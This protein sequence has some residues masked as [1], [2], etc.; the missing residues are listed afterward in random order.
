MPGFIKT[1]LEPVEMTSDNRWFCPSCNYL[2]SSTKKIECKK[3]RTIVIFQLQCYTMFRSNPIKDNRKVKCSSDPLKI[4]VFCQNTV[5]FSTSFSLQVIINHSD[6]LQAVHYWSFKRD[7]HANK[8]LKCNNTS[9]TPEQQKSL[10]NETSYV[11]F[12]SGQ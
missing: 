11:L 2:T 9:V 4:P 3:E 7:K 5:S 10:T 6:T 8:W 12:Y 1:F